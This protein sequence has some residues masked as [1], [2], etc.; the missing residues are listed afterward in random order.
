MRTAARHRV[1]LM[2]TML[3]CLTAIGGC[4]CRDNV[5]VTNRADAPILVR[6]AMPWPSY[7]PFRSVCHYEFQ[8]MP[9]T[10]WHSRLAT[11]DERREFDIM[12]NGAT[13]VRL[14]NTTAIH[15]PATTFAAETG[16][17]AHLFIA[18]DANGNFTLTG[19]DETG[20]PITA[21]RS[22]LDWFRDEE[23]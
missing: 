4:R 10:T 16:E 3:F 11:A 13:I 14:I 15:G 22:E 18:L 23:R 7:E 17:H 19:E 8:V 20:R 5:S 1:A 6:M 21:T 9:N 2:L 12:P